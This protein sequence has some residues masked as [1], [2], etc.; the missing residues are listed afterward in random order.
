MAP[1]MILSLCRFL[2]Y[3]KSILQLSFGI[4]NRDLLEFI[5]SYSLTPRFIL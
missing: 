2:K 1:V 3:I 4:M 5:L